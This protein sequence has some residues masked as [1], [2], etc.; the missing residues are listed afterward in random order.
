MRLHLE[1]G[2]DQRD[3]PALLDFYNAGGTDY[4]CLRF[5]FGGERRPL[6]RDWRS[7]FLHDRSA[8]R[9]P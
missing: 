5:R 9:L 1:L 6:A 2:P 3:F 4:L 7:L 8:R